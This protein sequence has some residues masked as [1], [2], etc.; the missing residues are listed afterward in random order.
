MAT[1]E[2]SAVGLIALLFSTRRYS[3]LTGA[4]PLLAGSSSLGVLRKSLKAYGFLR[5]PRHPDA[6]RH[7]R[8]P[9]PFRAP[10]RARSLHVIFYLY[11]GPGLQPAGCAAVS[12]SR[13]VSRDARPQPGTDPLPEVTEHIL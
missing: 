6:E 11:R 1:F 3:R 2:R 4:S 12:D 13:L 8:L 5:E 10:S 9:R 7:D